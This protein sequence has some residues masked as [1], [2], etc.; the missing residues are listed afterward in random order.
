MTDALNS[1][2]FYASVFFGHIGAWAG[3][4]IDLAMAHPVITFQTFALLSIVIHR[5]GSQVG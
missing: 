4:A 2:T 5:R 3:Q 1:A